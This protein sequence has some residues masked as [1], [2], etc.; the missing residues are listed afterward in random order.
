MLNLICSKLL[1]NLDL[2]QLGYVL[3]DTTT[4]NIIRLKA[5]NKG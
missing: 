4:P 3:M 2:K 1:V 5:Q